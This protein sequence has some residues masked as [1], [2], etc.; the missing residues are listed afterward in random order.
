MSISSRDVRQFGN[1][2]NVTELQLLSKAAVTPDAEAE[3]KAEAEDEG[4][5]ASVASVA[6]A[7]GA[8]RADE[9]AEDQCAGGGEREGG[10]LAVGLGILGAL[11]VLA[12]CDGEWYSGGRRRRARPPRVGW[13][14]IWSLPRTLRR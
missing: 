5:A 7:A 6:S 3:A 4:D 9:D 2:Q 14:R 1:F 11:F 13:P 8:A 12:V 10:D